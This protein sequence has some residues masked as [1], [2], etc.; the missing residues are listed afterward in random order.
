MNRKTLNKVLF[1]SGMLL[2]SVALAQSPLT[3]KA[4]DGLTLHAT[5]YPSKTA[6]AVLLMFH[7]AG[8]NKAEYAPIAPE[9]VKLGF[10]GLALDQR[11]GGSLFDADNQTVLQAGKSSTFMETLPDLEAALT[12]AKA[13]YPEKPIWL[14]GSSYTSALV[15]LVAA[16]HP[17]VQAILS[18]SP[19]EYLEGNNTVKDAAKK[20]GSTAVF[21]TS[22]KSEAAAAKAIFNAVKSPQKT[23]FTP[24]KFGKHGASILRPEMGIFGGQETWEAVKA[25]VKGHLK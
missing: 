10:A 3:L 17:E 24:Q 5:H 8:S 23:L 22:A 20:L 16:R 9:F 21:I 2:G 12:W 25:F 18:F 14:L 19:D 4:S 6:K 1:S 13:T 11:S 15:F 7:Q